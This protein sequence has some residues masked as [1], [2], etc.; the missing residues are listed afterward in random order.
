MFTQAPEITID[1]TIGNVIVQPT[2]TPTATST[3]QSTTSTSTT[4][5]PTATP[6]Y[7]FSPSPKPSVSVT[8]T[9]SIKRYKENALV[10]YGY[11]PS[12]S[13]VSLKGFGIS[14]RVT[15]EDNGFFVFGGIYSLTSR[16][17]EVCVQA[18]DNQGRVT[19]PSCI[20]ALPS[21]SL[22]PLEVGP[23]LLSPTI[24]VSKNNIQQGE[25]AVLSG[26]TIPNSN[27]NVFLSKKENGL[28]DISFVKEVSAYSLPILSLNA[29]EKGEYSVTLPTKES[30]EYKIFT[31]SKYGEDLSNKSNTLKFVVLTK[32]T[33]LFQ[34]IVEF[35]LLN[36]IMVVVIVE[37]LVIMFLLFKALKST[38]KAKKQHTE[39]DYL[40]FIKV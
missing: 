9:P 19:Q 18:V 3:S 4:A 28:S 5:T 27:V 31:S 39:K 35:L 36:K 20:P 23:I 13:E 2:A 14:E 32:L 34:K 1:A 6:V 33:T 25:E 29:N 10:I 22:I 7:S 16:Y 40:E 12:N 21:D 17:P 37:A 24:S 26:M 8:S 11:G 15:S 30:S 38:T